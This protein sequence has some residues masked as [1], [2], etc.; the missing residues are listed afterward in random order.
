MR[1]RQAD[2]EEVG[3]VV[4][5]RR[6]LHVRRRV[7]GCNKSLWLVTCT[8]HVSSKLSSWAEIAASM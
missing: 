8:L 7:F 3:K 1:R 4:G 6:L 2:N 5:L